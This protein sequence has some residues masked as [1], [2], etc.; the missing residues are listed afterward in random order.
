RTGSP[1]ARSRAHGRGGAAGE[2]GRCRRYDRRCMIDTA[3]PP[4]DL[5]PGIAES[6]TAA[7]GE[8]PSAAS[9]AAADGAAR[10][11]PRP[12]RLLLARPAVTAQT[13][14]M[15]T[16]RAPGVDLSDRGREQAAALGARLADLP[17][18]AVYASPI[19]RTM[20]TAAAVAGHHGLQVE[21]L[22]GVI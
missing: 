17:V 3:V 22:Q 19:E 5:A 9:E 20:Q 12:T 10:T 15:L 11:P 13:G 2:A 1:G 8:E 18:R 6:S 16:G 14:P 4:G 21:E 7:S